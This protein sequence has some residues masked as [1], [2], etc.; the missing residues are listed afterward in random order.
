MPDLC[1]LERAVMQ[2]LWA[3]GAMTARAVRERLRRRPKESAVRTVLR[4]LEKKSYVT[5]AID[6]RSNVSRAARARRQ[7]AAEAV[8]RIVE[9]FCNGSVEGIL[10]CMIDAKMLDRHR[11]HPPRERRACWAARSVGPCAGDHTMPARAQAVDEAE[12]NR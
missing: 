9:E 5:H 3:G 4:R 7:V 2:L 8:R 6:G 12:K 11:L 10:M 1:E